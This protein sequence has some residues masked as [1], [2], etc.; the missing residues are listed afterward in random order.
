MPL[1]DIEEI[2]SVEVP[3]APVSV[4]PFG[5]YLLVAAGTAGLQCYELKG[6]PLRIEH[7]LSVPLEGYV[8]AVRVAERATFPPPVYVTSRG[9]G[10]HVL[11][12][13]EVKPL[14]IKVVGFIPHPPGAGICDIAENRYG[15][16][17]AALG[18]RLVVG[19][20]KRRKT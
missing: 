14:R 11:S 16:V 1:Y 18:W 19:R 12:I 4:A 9:R 15:H 3:G 5:D 7:V 2:A 10:T 17:I 13:A 20:L 6:K 8:D